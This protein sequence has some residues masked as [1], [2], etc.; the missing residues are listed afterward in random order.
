LNLDLSVILLVQ[1]SCWNP[2][3]KGRCL[4]FYKYFGHQR[5]YI[6][7]CVSLF[8]KSSLCNVG[9]TLQAF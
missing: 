6:Y 4:I 8:S 1:R 7:E 5:M 2:W 3:N 9:D